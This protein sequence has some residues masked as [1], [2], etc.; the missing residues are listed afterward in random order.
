MSLLSGITSLPGKALDKAR[1]LGGTGGTAADIDN[2]FKSLGADAKNSIFDKVQKGT[3]SFEAEKAKAY[4]GATNPGLLNNAK[5][6]ATSAAE[7]GYDAAK[8]VVNK[9]IDIEKSIFEAN[10]KG[11]L[12]AFKSGEQAAT[13]A[14]SQA[15]AAKSTLATQGAMDTT[16]RNLVDAA[17]SAVP[18]TVKSIL[19][20]AGKVAGALKVL[21]K[22]SPFLV[23]IIATAEEVGNIDLS[24]NSLGKQICATGGAISGRVGGT[25]TG[26]AIAGAGT[27]LLAATAPAWVP[28]LAI[29]AVG[30]G[31]ACALAY[32]GDQVGG[33]IGRGV[34]NFAGNVGEA[35]LGNIFRKP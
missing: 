12:E 13:S 18:S 3:S 7:R 2:W 30:L 10:K 6:L 31:A 33:W 5:N 15:G 24:K 35:T 27:A 32:A 11:V 4:K 9:A 1:N 20:E 23:P 26:I 8:T 34:G 19:P 14:T 16:I 25:L 29:G 22:V 21:G 28:G 17:K